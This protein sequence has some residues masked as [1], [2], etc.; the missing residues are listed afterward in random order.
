[1]IY[2][3]LVSF[4]QPGAPLSLVGADAQTFASGI[5]DL[6]GSGV[7]TAPRQIFGTAAVFGGD[8]GVGGIRPELNVTIGTTLTSGGATTLDASFQAAIDTGAG[9]AYA[10]G[11]WVEIVSQGGIALADA[12]A[13]AV[14][15]R[16]PFLP[17]MPASMRPRY[18]RLLF[19]PT[20]AGVTPDGSFL[21]GTIASAIV[22]MVRDDLANKYVPKNFAVA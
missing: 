1:M 4:V 9:F 8:Q 16:V 14:I 15:L 6:L 5:V 10:P 13:G 19:S 21:T 17:V 2:D 7:G 12:I 11:P 3:S 20:T 22:T 18:L